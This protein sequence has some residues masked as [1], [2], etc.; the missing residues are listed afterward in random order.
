M[1]R[2]DFLFLVAP[3]KAEQDRAYEAGYEA[4]VK[5]ADGEKEMSRFATKI[6][7]DF[8]LLGAL[9]ARIDQLKK[10]VKA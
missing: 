5:G 6:E 10:G 3:S 4:F 1:S 2:G 9:S 8:F 7:R